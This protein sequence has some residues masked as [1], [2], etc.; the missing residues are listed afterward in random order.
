[1]PEPSSLVASLFFRALK[2]KK[3]APLP[4]FDTP[5]ARKL[6][7]SRAT[8][9]TSSTTCFSPLFP[10]GV[11]RKLARAEICASFQPSLW[12][13]RAC[14]SCEVKRE[15]KAKREFSY[16]EDA[17]V[18]LRAR[19]SKREKGRQFLPLTGGSREISCAHKGEIFLAAFF[20]RN[21][22][23]SFPYFLLLSFL[24]CT[25]VRIRGYKRP[26]L[27]ASLVHGLFAFLFLSF[28]RDDLLQKLCLQ[29][30]CDASY[31]NAIFL[32]PLRL[33]AFF[34]LFFAYRRYI[35]SALNALP[36]S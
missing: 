3:S 1:M 31:A 32:C 16:G 24:T 29:D 4:R 14:T 33:F 22:F 28:R 9:W 12:K 23:L 11:S 36:L 5:D 19:A 2:P 10:P 17:L 25:R 30:L 6:A 26:S 21:A 34:S 27:Q 7:S 20:D 35:T 8:C 15:I 13:H 18:V